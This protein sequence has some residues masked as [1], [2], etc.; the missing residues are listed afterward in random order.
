M[1]VG[2]ALG[3][4]SGKEETQELLSGKD[5]NTKSVLRRADER[6]PTDT[7]R[8]S[9]AVEVL[10]LRHAEDYIRLNG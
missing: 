3:L 4:V 6:K 10:V 9:C 1:G 8:A 5:E 7:D 2:V